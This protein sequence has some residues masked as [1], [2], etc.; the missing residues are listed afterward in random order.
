VKHFLANEWDRAHRQKRGGNAILLSLDEEWAESRYLSEP[1]ET[2]SAEKLYDRRWALTLLDEVLARL[3]RE[4]DA[5][6][7]CAEFEALKF[8]LTGDQADYGEVAQ[9]LKIADAAVKVAVHRLR[10]R[11]RAL[12]RAEIAQTV[13]TADEVEAELNH[14]FSA[15]S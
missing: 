15:L 7:K 8:C 14:L 2:V 12:I 13:A 5:V 6:G 11:Y 10:K 3:R 1:A 4:M 9:K